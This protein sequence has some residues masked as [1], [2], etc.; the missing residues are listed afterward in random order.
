MKST[1]RVIAISLVFASLVMGAQ[2]QSIK[3][4]TAQ[5]LRFST[6]PP[7][8]DIGE[9]GIRAEASSR[10]ACGSTNKQ[11]NNSSQQ[12]LT[13]LV[14]V[15]GATPKGLVWG[16]TTAEH[17][18]FWFYVP[19]FGSGAG[20][21]VLQKSNQTV[22][23]TSV[24]LPKKGGFVRVSLP[25]KVQPLTVNKQYHWFFDVYC[26]PNESPY[27]VHGWIK[28]DLLS[29]ALES[30]LK[31]MTAKQ[32]VVTLAGQGIWYDALAIS[33]SNRYLNPR[34]TD[35]VDLL[36][37]VGLGDVASEPLFIAENSKPIP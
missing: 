15:Y 1:T 35:W 14:P 30:K 34:D 16:K 12:P 36:S 23:E 5:H 9:P 17:P 6:P 26:Q 32:R 3:N 11:M 4:T 37:S 10:G 7:S 22:Y 25:S 18:T 27:F 19:F 28:R 33:A 21:F 29:P 24:T 8:Q 2:A 13:A 20:K 31:K